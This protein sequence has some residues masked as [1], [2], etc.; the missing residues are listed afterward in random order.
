M[1]KK[2]IIMA[3]TQRVE[4]LEKIVKSSGITLID[5]DNENKTVF[6][7]IKDGKFTQDL[8]TKTPETLET[9]NI[10]NQPI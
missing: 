5:P 1:K 2:Q 6:I 10:T 9:T 3:L 4:H 7:G 8:I